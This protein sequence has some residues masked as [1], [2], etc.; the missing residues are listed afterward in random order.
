MIFMQPIKGIVDKEIPDNT[1]PRAIEVEAISPRRVMSIGKELRSIGSEVVSFR[2]KVI[3]DDVE[4]N[5]DSAMVS[6]LNQSFK[7]FGATVGTV[8]CE[9]ENAIITPVALPG[10]I[11]DWHQLQ[12][13]DSEV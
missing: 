11:G 2:A 12:S 4:E 13:S 6:A 3:V 9:R 1:A 5:H 8:G 10:K 7:I